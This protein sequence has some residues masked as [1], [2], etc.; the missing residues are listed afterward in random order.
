MKYDDGYFCNKFKYFSKYSSF[1]L[2]STHHHK[3]KMENSIIIIQLTFA[4]YVVILQIIITSIQESFQ[5]L[6]PPYETNCEKDFHLEESMSH[7]IESEVLKQYNR[8]SPM[9]MYKK[10]PLFVLSKCSLDRVSN[11]SV[12]WNEITRNCDKKFEGKRECRS[13]VIHSNIGEII[14]WEDLEVSYCI[15]RI[16]LS[17]ALFSD[18]HDATKIEIIQYHDGRKVRDGIVHNRHNFKH[19]YLVRCLIHRCL[20]ILRF[21]LGT[22]N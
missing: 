1:L 17:F 18:F 2:L 3:G 20:L 13:D 16:L 10:S 6:P 14:D 15:V 12:G 11:K 9:S 5:S 22:K 21:V 7:C 8:L 19:R 4:I